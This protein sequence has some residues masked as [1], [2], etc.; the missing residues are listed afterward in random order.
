MSTWRT[1]LAMLAA[2]AAVLGLIA[3]ASPEPDRVTDRGLYEASAAQMIVPDCSDL[4]CFRVLVPW[5]LGRIPGPSVVRW[6]A[7]AA[8]ANAGSAVGVWLLCLA[9]GF[10]RRAAWMA[11]AISG[12]GFGSLYTLHDPFTS[13]PLMFAIGPIATTAL[14]TGRF[15]IATAIGVVGVFAKEFAAAPLY[16]FAACAVL[17]RRWMTAIR[18][19]VAGNAAFIAWAMLTI[20]LMLRFDYTYG[21][22]GNGSADFGH[23]AA[24]ALWLEHQ[25]ARGIAFAMFNEFGALYIL[26]PAGLL[27][28]PRRLRRLV[29]VSLPI[30]A[31]F[32]YVQ[33]PDRGLW[34]FHYL[35]APLA[36]L[37]LERAPAPLAWGT[38]VAFAIGNLRVGAQLPIAGVAR[39]AIALSLLLAIASAV[40]AWRNSAD[41]LIAFDEGTGAVA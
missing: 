19:F 22:N 31:V 11:A 21:W 35:V 39:I 34:N 8:H 16:A 38:I 18:A 41:R 33:Q 12:L 23:G 1:A 9:L 25:S 29:L 14:V 36:V 2:C 20:T 28:A 15:A 4:Q 24:L 40:T 7:Y 32:G 5:V 6:K 10:Q 17:E 3:W 30:A 37:V 26:A 27:F 13:D